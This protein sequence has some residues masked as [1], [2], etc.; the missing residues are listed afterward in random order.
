MGF[1]TQGKD[2]NMEMKWNLVQERAQILG[3]ITLIAQIQEKDQILVTILTQGK[4]QNME[5]KWNLAQERVQVLGMI[6]L[7]AQGQGKGRIS[8]T[9]PTQGKAQNMEMIMKK[10]NTRKGSEFYDDSDSDSY[11]D[12]TNRD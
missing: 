10:T 6:S 12:G 8:V 3:M 5:M 7:M 1:L 4:D 2:Q 11:D 9:I